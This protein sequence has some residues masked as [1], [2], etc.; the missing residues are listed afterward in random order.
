M[1]KPNKEEKKCCLLSNETKFKTHQKYFMPG[2]LNDS[3]EFG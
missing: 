2:K 3:D 1:K